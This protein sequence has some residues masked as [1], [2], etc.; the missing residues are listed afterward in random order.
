MKKLLVFL[1]VMVLCLSFTSCGGENPYE[2]YAKY[3]ELFLYLE[4]EDYDRANAYI[5]DFFEKT[6]TVSK[7]QESASDG[8]TEDKTKTKV[9]T[10]TLD[11]WQDYFE[12]KLE[13]YTSENAFGEL[14]SFFPQMQFRLK[15]TWASKATN[16]NIIYE[17]N[18]TDAYACRFI[19][20]TE[21]GEFTEGEKTDDY[22]TPNWGAIRELD[23][24]YIHRSSSLFGNCKRN[25]KM[26]GNLATVTVDM[27]STVKILRIQGT[28][29]IAE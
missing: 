18:C 9:I 17:Y 22:V 13:L 6:E 14:D 23:Y 29:T 5:Q 24:R 19:Y 1:L 4:E 21:T 3:E 27:Y 8:K 2:K 7:E 12:I 28:I 15:E 16:M 26:E 11:N 25:L 20:N 10:V